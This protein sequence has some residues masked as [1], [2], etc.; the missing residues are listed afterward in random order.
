[1]V[2]QA[3]RFFHANQINSDQDVIIIKN[4]ITIKRITENNKNDLNHPNEPF[5][6]W[7]KFLTDGKW[8][9]HIQKFRHPKQQCF[10]MESIS[11]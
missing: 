11:S 10:P 4:M 9:Y 1:M 7:S 5:Q 3:K 8:D 2:K 6:V